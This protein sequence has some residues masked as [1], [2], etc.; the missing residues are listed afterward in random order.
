VSFDFA[1]NALTL[2]QVSQTQFSTG[3]VTAYGF[4]GGYSW[5]GAELWGR[6][7]SGDRGLG[8]CSRSDIAAGAC[9]P[10]TNGTLKTGGG[11]FN[12]LDGAGE[13]DAIVLVLDDSN[14]HW[15]SLWVSSLD[16]NDAANDDEEGVLYFGD[17]YSGSFTFKFG[18]FGNLVEGDLMSLMDDA[19]RAAVAASTQL[20]FLPYG[21][22][23]NDYLVWK[24]SHD[25][26]VPVPG[27]LALFSL[28]L[29]GLGM[30]RRKK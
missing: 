8:V 6:N 14:R 15:T 7:N 11:D 18:D 4:S 29:V 10:S 19:T 22:G 12:E 27:T 21:I 9:T 20:A 25:A 16:G 5:Y 3:G 1:A 13:L 17:N 30:V 26:A 2:Q 28:G 23:G 24:G